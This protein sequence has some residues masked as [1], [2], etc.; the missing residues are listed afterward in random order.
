M[1]IT[2]NGKEYTIKF[3]YAPVLK[4]GFISE[5]SKVFSNN[6]VEEELLFIPRAL[7]IGLQVNHA[8]EFGFSNDEEKAEKED[9]ILALFGKEVDEGNLDC[10]QVFID[11]TN[12][13]VSNSFLK[14]M[15]EKEMQ[16]QSKASAQKKAPK[17]AQKN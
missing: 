7:L 14:G 13:L 6:N 5:F 12:E 1:K 16:N 15:L 2:L 4:N 10:S 8:D 11:I 3:G 9:K 17:T